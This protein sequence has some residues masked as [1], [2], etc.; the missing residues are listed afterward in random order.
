M[1]ALVSVSLLMAVV[2]D[3]MLLPILL[4]AFYKPKQKTTVAE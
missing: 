1:G 4:L 3:L 2:A